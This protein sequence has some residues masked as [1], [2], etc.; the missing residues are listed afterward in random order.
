MCVFM[1]SNFG[2]FY[3][4][5]KWNYNS[6]D[7]F[8]LT[9]KSPKHYVELQSCNFGMDVEGIIKKIIPKMVLCH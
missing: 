3:R 7:D 5:S 9:Q 8:C 6:V 4:G 1:S 2:Q